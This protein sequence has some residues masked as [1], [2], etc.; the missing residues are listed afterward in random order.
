M[1]HDH[2]IPRGFQIVTVFILCWLSFSASAYAA[3]GT[4]FQ[5]ARGVTISVDST[6]ARNR[7]S[8]EVGND[9]LEIDFAGSAPTES[10]PRYRLSTDAK[11]PLPPDEA[12]E[13]WPESRPRTE[14]DSGDAVVVFSSGF[15]LAAAD[16][17]VV[18]FDLGRCVTAGDTAVWLADERI[19]LTGR[20][21]SVGRVEATVDTDLVAWIRGLERL[22]GLGPTTVIPGRGAPGGAE[23]L[24]DQIERLDS[25]RQEV[26]RG[27]LKGQSAESI[28]EDST[29]DWFIDWHRAD[30]NGSIA[31]VD[32]MVYEVGGLRM[33]WELKERR[34]LRQG[35][36]PTRADDAWTPPRKILWRN[37]WPE[38]LP[39]L[40]IVAPGVDIVPFDSTEEAME[41]IEGADAIIGSATA[42]LLTA[43]TDLRW[44]QVGSAGVERYLAMPRLGTGEVLLTNGQKLA[45]PEI[46]EHVMALTRAVAR[47]LGNAVS[48]QNRMVWERSGVTSASPL[49]RL[50]GKTM[51]V[52]GL[53]GIGTEVARLAAA[54]EMRVT[55]I[56]SSRRSGPPFVD[57]VGLTE[58]LSA[59]AAE[60]DVVVNCLPM[61]PDTTDIFNE[62]LFEAMKTTAIFVNVGRGGTVETDAL[63]AAL[64]SGKIAGA[65]LDVT[66]PEP[67]PDGHPLWKA[68][69]VIITP[70]Y[71]AWS[72]A[73]RERRWLLYR[74]NLRRFVAGER[75]LS[76]V[77]PERGY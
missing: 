3:D 62:A 5:P 24:T 2:K 64:S 6:T 19:L 37:Y 54:A 59:F 28:A 12:I 44:V 9:R 52:V 34:G 31:A 29:L 1:K 49:Q 73:G 42:D 55:G 67:L 22:R 40:S 41:H 30:A 47:G 46:A 56:R 7:V 53:G 18:F 15:T 35:K 51:L 26:E 72:D 13:L 58:D 21:A 38:R 60:A 74:E 50:R 36:S 4:A 17:Q 33:P 10:A 8:I 77:D 57:R 43:G 32:A 20:M 71:A 25:L 16:R 14:T 45:S 23:V 61:T 70:H 68:P 39:L 48:A 11:G 69:N 75:M 76:V 63:I 27:L 66:D 65:G